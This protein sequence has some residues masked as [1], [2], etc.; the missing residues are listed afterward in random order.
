MNEEI[1]IVMSPLCRSFESEGTTVQIDI[2]GDG[3]GGW[4]LEVI[5]EFGNSTVWDDS[6]SSDQEALAE[7]LGTIDG[8]GIESLIGSPSQSANQ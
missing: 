5:D 2:F 7:A 6:F 3:D 4:L 1:D 8:E